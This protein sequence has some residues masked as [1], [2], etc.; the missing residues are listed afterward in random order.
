[1]SSGKAPTQTN[2]PVLTYKVREFTKED[3]KKAEDILISAKVQLILR[4]P[5]FG[6]ICT[7]LATI[8]D[9][10][11]GTMC[12]DGRSIR[13]GTAFVLGIAEEFP[14]DNE[15]Q[16]YINFIICHEIMHGILQHCNLQR[17]RHRDIIVQTKNGVPIS[18]WNI[19]ADY[20]VNYSIEKD[21]ESLDNASKTVSK[22]IKKPKDALYDNKYD[23]SFTTEMVY[24][25]LLEEMEKNKGKGGVRQLPLPSGCLIDDHEEGKKNKEKANG[26]GDGE[27]DEK[28]G[29][30]NGQGLENTDNERFWREVTGQALIQHKMQKQGTLPAGLQRLHDMMFE[31]P[32]ISWYEELRNYLHTIEGYNYRNNPPNKRHRRFL[33][34]SMYGEEIKFTFAVDTSGSMSE[35]D[36]KQAANELE[37]IFG[38]FETCKVRVMACDAEI[39]SDE[40]WEGYTSLA[41]DVGKMR[42]MYKGGGGTSFT[43]VF[44][45]Q[46]EDTT[47]LI[48]FTDGYGTFGHAPPY[49]VIFIRGENDLPADQ[50]PFGVVLTIP[51]K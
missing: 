49:D 17:V 36:L 34:P 6:I 39:Q 27:G 42:K 46:E 7:R 44:D 32:K 50:F 37:A 23:F 3:I 5:F 4:F 24:D 21:I 9:P 48:Y 15:G 29:E 14:T 13:V 31:P 45:A 25:A 12:T 26:E 19:A 28:G 51:K 22:F 10:T 38:A 8:L 11:I 35:D 43:P 1:M 2:N 20:I 33:L 30:G 16:A 41:E 40:I 47:L 18:L